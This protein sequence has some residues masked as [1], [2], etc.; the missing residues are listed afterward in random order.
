MCQNV[1]DFNPDCLRLLGR[2][3]SQQDLQGPQGQPGQRE[4]DGGVREARIRRKFQILILF[5]TF[6]V[7]FKVTFLT[8]KTPLSYD[9]HLEYGMF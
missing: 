4:V 9:R 8:I 3:G 5:V 6:F 2:D 7:S 1:S